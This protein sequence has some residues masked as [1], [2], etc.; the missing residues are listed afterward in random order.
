MDLAVVVE[1]GEVGVIIKMRDGACGRCV[2]PGPSLVT[3]VA[4][5]A[6]G[7]APTRGPAADSARARPMRPE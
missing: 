7:L 5:A 6:T 3:R 4:T 1:V 2:R